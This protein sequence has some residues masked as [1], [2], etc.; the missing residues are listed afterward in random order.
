LVTASLFLGHTPDK[1]SGAKVA[2]ACVFVEAT[3]LALMWVASTSALAPFALN[4]CRDPSLP[5]AKALV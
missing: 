5:W 3:G 2:L 4:R 1:L